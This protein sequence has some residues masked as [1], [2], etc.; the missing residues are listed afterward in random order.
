MVEGPKAT[1]VAS[2]EKINQETM[3]EFLQKTSVWDFYDITRDEYMINSDNDKKDLIV[4]FF[5][6]MSEGT[7]SF[8]SLLFEFSTS[9]F[10]SIISFSPVCSLSLLS[11]KLC[12]VSDA[13]PVID[14]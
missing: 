14:L 3:Q 7:I 12:S 1:Q 11:I 8:V 6:Y 9:V 2:I 10:S 4:K 13:L 5:N